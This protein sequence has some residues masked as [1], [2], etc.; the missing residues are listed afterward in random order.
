MSK[1]S[2]FHLPE[3][4]LVEYATGIG[5]QAAGLAV[6]CHLVFCERCRGDLAASRDGLAA[7]AAGLP[8]PA[9]DP[10]ARQRLLGQLGDPLPPAP[11]AVRPELQWLP[12]PMH[13][14][15]AGRARWRMLVPGARGIDL[16]VGAGE[17][18]ARLVRFRPGFVIPL[19]DHAGPEYTVIFSGRLEDTGAVAER[20]D[21]IYREAGVR[22]IQTITDDQE[23]VALVVNER[24]LVP[25]TLVGR[26]LRFIAG[27]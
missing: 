26:V 17:A 14:Y 18:T 5:S 20:G 9:V 27:V 22:H 6:D 23:C 8:G 2:N 25:L 3:Q 7:L 24:P 21:V 11:P 10:A 13:P 4:G 15:L 19:H 1:D 16:P 12:W